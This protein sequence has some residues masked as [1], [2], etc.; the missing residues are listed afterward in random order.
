MAPICSPLCPTKYAELL[1]N[2]CQKV[3]KHHQPICCCAKKNVTQSQHFPLSVCVL[4]WKQLQQNLSVFL[5]SITTTTTTIA[6]LSAPGP[7]ATYQ[8]G[9]SPWSIS[10]RVSSSHNN[11]RHL[12]ESYKRYS[13]T[14]VVVVRRRMFAE[15]V[16]DK[17]CLEFGSVCWV[18]AAGGL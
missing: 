3:I 18:A 6:A 7:T 14:I 2:V 5:F 16:L 11:N 9:F 15:K 4:H 8:P 10:L 13:S 17:Y 1:R 12:R